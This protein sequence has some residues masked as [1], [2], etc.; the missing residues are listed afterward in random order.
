LRSG[1]DQRFDVLGVRPVR[2]EILLRNLA[3]VDVAFTCGR[4][5]PM[6]LSGVTFSSLSSCA[7]LMGFIPQSILQVFVFLDGLG[8]AKP[9]KVS[10]EGV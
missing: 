1:S 7:V 4:H 9:I 2:D 8:A 6:P 3:H 5:A 10:G